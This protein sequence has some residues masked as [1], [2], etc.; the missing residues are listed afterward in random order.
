MRRTWSVVVVAFAAAGLSGFC[1]DALAT[2]PTTA[3]KGFAD[4]TA[5]R[6]P[7][8]DVTTFSMDAA[9]GDLDGDGNVDL[10]VAVEFRPN[11]VWLNRGDG[12]FVDE[13][14]ARLPQ[15][16]HDSE[17]VALADFD[18]DGDLDAIIV[19][20]DDRLNE[21][22]LNNGAGVFQDASDRIPVAGTSNAVAAAD[23]DGDGDPDILVG[24]N[25]QNALLLNDGLGHFTDVTSDRLPVAQ[26]VTQDVKVGD[27]DA[28]GDLDIVVANEGQ[29]RI[30]I[31]L[32]GTVFRD[33]S[34]TRLPQ[35]RMFQETR[36]AELADVD[37]DGDLDLFFGNVRLFHQ[38]DPRNRLLI[39]DGSGVFVDETGERLPP[40][41]ASTMD[42]MFADLDSDGDLDLVLADFGD[43]TG[44]TAKTPYRALVND[45]T[46]RFQDETRRLFPASARGNGMHI[47]PGY[48]EGGS[49][50]ELYLASRGGLDRLLT[51]ISAP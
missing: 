49:R 42:G 25:G 9:A 16:A 12:S 2:S 46:G 40:D 28:D 31:N 19:S 5:D 36:D 38:T 33:E 14:L 45:G 26:D 17:D 35:D 18:G 39:N 8:Q 10:I 24:N 13:S 43:L 7:S 23:F 1:L 21:F 48:F 51:P 44:R 6:L 15:I 4:A 22:Y 27:I 30:L 47:E 11:L 37:G 34:D 29:N 32:G 41:Q 20:E 3:L 50:V